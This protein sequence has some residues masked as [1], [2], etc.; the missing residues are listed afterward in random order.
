MKKAIILLVLFLLP[1]IG[2]GALSPFFEFAPDYFASHGLLVSAVSA[3][4]Q[5]FL[6]QND[7]LNGFD[8]WLDNAGEAGAAVFEVFDPNHNLIISRTVSIPHIDPVAGGER[9]RFSFNQR[10]V[11]SSGQYTIAVTSPL[12]Q[13]RLYYGDRIRFLAHNAPYVSEYLNGVAMLGGEKQDFSFKFALYEGSE[14]KPPVIS[15]VDAVSLSLNQEKISFYADEPVDYQVFYGLVG[16]GYNRQTDLFGDFRFCGPATGGCYSV[17]DV[18]AGADYE[19]KIVAKDRW[20][21]ETEFFG[22]FAV[23]EDSSA[24]PSLT[25]TPSYSLPPIPEDREAPVISNL[26]AIAITD[27]SMEAAW[28]TNEGANSW[29][30]ISYSTE[31]ITITAVSDTT[32]ELEHWLMTEPVLISGTSYIATITSYDL[33]NNVATASFTFTTPKRG[34]TSPSPTPPPPS[35]SLLPTPTGSFLPSGTPQPSVSP[36][37]P[38][39]PQPVNISSDPSDEDN[40]IIRWN[41]YQSHEPSGGYRLDILNENGKLE[42]KILAPAGSRQ[43]IVENIPPGRYTV[44]VYADD[45]GVFKKVAEPTTLNRPQKSFTEKFLGWLPYI[46]LG[47]MAVIFGA[48]IAFK[49]LRKK[50]KSDDVTLSPA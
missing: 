1:L 25:P 3:P 44:I 27:K 6:P 23:P 30:L 24:I 37:P 32:F 35:P 31:L 18:K 34:Q 29:L 13:L 7:F 41:P 17:I 39:E 47:L 8:L 43:A 50:P 9:F 46:L 48:V 4:A 40:I 22:T 42:Q 45:N 20:G 38:G 28:T 14:T 16:Q 49:F 12:P 33:A 5:I 21:N 19:F 15:H 11:L 10:S 36:P 2:Q 26:R